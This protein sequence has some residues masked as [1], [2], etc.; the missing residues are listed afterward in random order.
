MDESVLTIEQ[1]NLTLPAG[2]E[3]R[4]D[5]IARDVARELAHMPVAQSLEIKSLS[6]PKVKIFNGETNQVIARRIAQSIHAQ[7]HS[8]GQVSGAYGQNTDVSVSQSEP[9]QHSQSGE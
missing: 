1:L 6:M 2:F 9:N 4:A 3:K 7:L 5:A 8:P